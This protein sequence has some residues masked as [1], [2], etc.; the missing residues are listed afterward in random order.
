MSVVDQRVWAEAGRVRR[1]LARVLLVL[2][3]TVAVTAIGWLLS[4]ASAGAD[5]LPT[6]PV[7]P[8]AVLS[9]VVP[10]VSAAVTTPTLPT[11]P[12]PALPTPPADLGQVTQQVH[13]AVAGVGTRVEPA[14]D[15]VPVTAAGPAGSLPTVTRGPVRQRVSEVQSPRPVALSGQRRHAVAAYGNQRAGGQETSPARSGHHLPLL[16][17]LQPAGTSDTSVHDA[18]GSAGGAGS[19]QVPFVTILGAVPGTVGMPAVPRL[20]VAP[21]HQPGTSP[22]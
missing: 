12:T 7:G 4:T 18:G 16:P 8:S 10:V 1:L 13:T 9:A 19:A 15:L 2:G 3:G 6:V 21:G 14:T 20:P 22:D 5:E 11:V 17:P